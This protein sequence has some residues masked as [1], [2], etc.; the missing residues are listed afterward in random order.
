MRRG[1]AGAHLAL[2]A[3]LGGC[4]AWHDLFQRDRPDEALI[5]AT[6]RAP[7]PA[8]TDVAV[9]LGCPAEQDGS[10]S[11]CLRCRVRAAV[12]SYQAGQVR[13]VIFSG[14]AAHNRWVEGEVMA[15]LAARAGVPAADLLV[16]GRALT[17]W[18]NLRYAGRI[19]RAHGFTTALV[20]SAAEHLPRARRFTEYYGIPSRYAACDRNPDD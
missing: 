19:M 7:G 3:S 16:E 6:L 11:A 18:Q 14:G 17:T 9:V 1:A 20:I 4:A 8:R 12:R 5:Q 10:A 15:E 13:A 2:L